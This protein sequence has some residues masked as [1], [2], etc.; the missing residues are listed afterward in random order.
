MGLINDILA[1]EAQFYFDADLMPGVESIS[2]TP[3]GGSPRTI[4]AQITREDIINV[5]EINAAPILIT[6]ENHA[7]RGILQSTMNASGDTVTLKY[8]VGGTSRTYRIGN[9]IDH[10]EHTL[11]FRVLGKGE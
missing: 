7:T 2:Y 3:F 4:K 6:V 1:D 8:R 9:P 10:D 11:T 5:G